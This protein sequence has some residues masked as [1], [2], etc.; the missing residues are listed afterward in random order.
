MAQRN[1]QNYL[2]LNILRMVDK[3]LLT[4]LIICIFR[5]L[6]ITSWIIISNSLPSWHM[7]CELYSMHVTSTVSV[8]ISPV[9]HPKSLNARAQRNCILLLL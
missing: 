1:R 7:K 5:S 9:S 6:C 2:K 8:L 4:K 3:N